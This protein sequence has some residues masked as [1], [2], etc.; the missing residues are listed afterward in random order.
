M[1]DRQGP[2]ASKT[3]SLVVLSQ[4]LSRCRQCSWPDR[5]LA[6]VCGAEQFSDVGWSHTVQTV[7]GV[8]EYF[9]LNAE[10]DRKPVQDVKIGGDIFIFPHPYQGPGGS[11]LSMLASLKAPMRSVL[12]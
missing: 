11:T 3:L 8:K 12:Q 1:F 7:M 6:E 10:V 2:T 4:I 9:E 5:V